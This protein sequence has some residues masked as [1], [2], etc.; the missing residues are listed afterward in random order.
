M[1]REF[2][3]DDIE[4]AIALWCSTRWASA[5]TS[6]EIENLLLR[7][8]G[9]SWVA[10][11]DDRIVGTVLG[12][13]DGRRGYIYHLVV[14][15]EFHGFGLGGQLLEKA[16]EGLKK[17][18]ILKCHVMVIDGNPSADFFWAKRGWKKQVTSQYS[19]FL[20]A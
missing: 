6:S 1:L 10:A 16:L 2:T 18:G 12:G 3:T 14:A 17:Q 9:L 19:L 13:H 8:P 11:S 4:D 15:D 7:N 20:D 5:D